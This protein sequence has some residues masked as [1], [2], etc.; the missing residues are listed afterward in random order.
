MSKNRRYT[1]EEDLVILREVKK[2][3]HNL[4]AAFLKAVPKISR[5]PES[6]S[7]R[8]YRTLSKRKEVC[9]A[10][11]SPKAAVKNRKNAKRPSVKAKQ[12]KFKQILNIIFG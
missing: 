2:S 3:P 12:S 9:I 11:L 6:I 7:L 4:Q 10:T 8:W 5:T 1:K